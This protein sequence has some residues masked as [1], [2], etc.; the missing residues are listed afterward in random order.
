MLSI[1][2]NKD[3]LGN[4][5]TTVNSNSIADY[6]DAVQSLHGLLFVGYYSGSLFIVSK[7]IYFE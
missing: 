6:N 5:I 1:L 4:L 3:V 2:G 7:S